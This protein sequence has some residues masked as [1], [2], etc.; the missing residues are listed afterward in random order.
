MC[1]SFFVPLS[2]LCPSVSLSSMPLSC[3]L[4]LSLSLALVLSVSRLRSLYIYI[5]PASLSPLSPPLSLSVFFFV[6]QNVLVV[7]IKDGAKGAEGEGAPLKFGEGM[8]ADTDS[9]PAEAASAGGEEA[10]SKADPAV[11]TPSPM[12]TDEVEQLA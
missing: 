4:S 10:A 6:S 9:V 3:P 7:S 5:P 8:D 1:F 12:E 11:E 2:H